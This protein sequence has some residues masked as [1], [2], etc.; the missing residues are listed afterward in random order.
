MMLIL[1]T[2]TNDKTV[3]C[4]KTSYLVIALLL[5]K[6]PTSVLQD[7]EAELVQHLI[8]GLSDDNQEIVDKCLELV[9]EVG[10]NLR[11]LDNAMELE[12]TKTADAI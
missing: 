2:A 1:K 4:R 12:Q 7:Y 11:K 3:E 5:N 9:S 10:C 8:N 6:L